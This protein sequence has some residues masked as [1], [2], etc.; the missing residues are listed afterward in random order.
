MRIVLRGGSVIAE[1]FAP[2]EQLAE[3]QAASLSEVKVMGCC[4]EVTKEASVRRTKMQAALMDKATEAD[5]P[6]EQA[7]ASDE[8]FALYDFD[9]SKIDWPFSDQQPLALTA[10]DKIRV[11]LDAAD[12]SGDWAFGQRIGEPAAE[13]Y[14]PRSYVGSKEDFLE[15]QAA[16]EAVVGATSRPSSAQSVLSVAVALYD[17]DPSTVDW[18]FEDDRPL[19]L[20]AGCEVQMLPLRQDIPSDWARG[21]LVG[22]PEVHGYF[23]KTYVGSKRHLFA[24]EQARDA[25]Q[26]VKKLQPV[27][28][29]VFALYNF[30]PTKMD[31]PFPDLSPLAF[32]AGDE[33]KLLPDEADAPS[34]WAFGQRA[35][36]PEATGYF[37]RSYVGS[38]EEMSEAQS[39][40]LSARSVSSVAVALYDFDP[41]GVDW[42]F[43]EDKPLILT[44]G[45][46]IQMLPVSADTPSD[47]AKGHV[48]GQPEIC[49]FFPRA[50]VGSKRHHDVV[51]QA[52]ES[53]SKVKGTSRPQSHSEVADSQRI[54]VF[55]LYEFDPTKIEWPF[56]DQPPLALSEGEAIRMWLDAS[57]EA[58]DWAFGQQVAEPHA[59]GYFPKAY[60]GSKE[61]LLEAQSMEAAA[62]ESASRPSSAASSDSVMVALYDFDPAGLAWPFQDAGPLVLKAGD[63]I[64]LLPADRE[65]PSDWVF[66]HHLAVPGSPGYLPKAYIGSRKH[67][68]VVAQ[69]QEAARQ[70]KPTIGPLPIE[71]ES[72]PEGEYE[73][74]VDNKFLRSPCKG[75]LHR[76]SKN[77]D[78][79]STECST[80]WGSTVRGTATGDGWLHLNNGLFL[81]LRIA[82]V[83]I[84]KAV[85]PVDAQG[86]AILEE[87]SENDWASVASEV[88]AL[89]DFDPARMDWPFPDHPPLALFAGEKV[90]LQPGGREALGD[91]GFGYRVADPQTK[92]L[93][94]R[95]YVGNREALLEAQSE[96]DTV[97][98][99][100]TPASLDSRTSVVIALYDFDP[101]SIEW[102][103][104]NLHSL[105]LVSGDEIQLLP[106][107]DNAPS[108]WALGHHVG[109]P[110][111]RGCFP[112]AYVGSRRHHKVITKAQ[113]AAEIARKARQQWKDQ[114]LKADD[115]EGAG[116]AHGDSE[117][118]ALYDFDPS[119][120]DW[121]FPDQKPLALSVG[122]KIVLLPLGVG[123]P[124]DWAFGHRAADLDSQ[125]YF[126]RAYIG[127]AFELSEALAAEEAL[128]QSSTPSSDGSAHS[129]A[130]ALYDFDASG[131]EW[132]FENLRP[133][134]LKAGDEVQLLPMGDG[135][136]NDWA[137]GH[138][139]GQPDSRGCFP[140]AYVGSRH[141]HRIVARAQAAA[142]RATQAAKFFEHGSSSPF[143]VF[144]L[145]DFDASKIDW[146]FEEHP[147]LTLTAGEKIVLLPGFEDAPGDWSLGHRAADR[148]QQGL[149]P[150]SYVG[151]RSEL[152]AAQGEEGSLEASLTPS[153][154]SSGVSVVVALHDFDPSTIEWPF[155]NLPSL[156]LTAGDEIQLLPMADDAPSD[157]A[158]GHHVGR[159]ESRGCF[160]KAYIGSKHH[161]K[162][163]EKVER[164]A[165]SAS[166]AQKDA[167][168]QGSIVAK[169]GEQQLLLEVFALYDFDPSK[170][171]WPFPNHHPLGLSAGEKI[172]LLPGTESVPGEWAFGHRV[173]DPSSQGFFPKAYVGSRDELW[174]AKA[175]EATLEKVSTP[176]SAVSA[177]SAVAVALFD[178]DPAAMEWPFPNLQP[179]AL[180]AGD[181]IQLLPM[182]DDA[183]TDWVLGHLVGEPEVRGCFPKDYIGSRH[184][185]QVVVQGQEAA[186]K[187]RSSSKKEAEE[188][189]HV[190]SS[191]SPSEL[192]A[193]Y[194]FDP[195]T[196]DWPFPENPPLGLI[197]GEKIVL[198]P[199]SDQA[200]GDWVVGQRAGD[201][202]AKGVLP[203]T[204][205]GTKEEL[206]D[207][208]ASSV[209]DG[210]ESA[211]S[212]VSLESSEITKQAKQQ[213]LV[214]Q[215]KRKHDTV[216]AT[217]EA[218]DYV[219]DNSQLQSPCKGILHRL[220]MHMDNVAW[221]EAT[222]WGSVV[223]GADMGNGWL[224]LTSGLY[225]PL[226]ISGIP[227][228]I[229]RS[230]INDFVTPASTPRTLAVAL[231]EFSPEKMDWPFKNRAPLPLAPGEEIELVPM[232]DDA[233]VEW[234]V[235]HPV[236]KPHLKGWFPRNYVGYAIKRPREGDSIEAS[237]AVALYPFSP[238]EIEWPFKTRSP[239]ALSPG[240][241]IQLI[242][243]KGDAEDE[244]W[245]LGHPV[246][247]PDQQGFFPK[248]YVSPPVKF[249]DA[250]GPVVAPVP[251]GSAVSVA[252]YT[253]DPAG[254]ERAF[255]HRSPLALTPG[256][257]I[258]LL[259]TKFDQPV[260]WAFGH[261]VGSPEATGYFPSKYV[262]VGEDEA[263][264]EDG[265]AGPLGIAL[266]SFDCSGTWPFPHR[267]PLSFSEGDAIKILPLQ[268]DPGMEWAFGHRVGAPYEKG[269]FP[270]SYISTPISF[271]DDTVL[272]SPAQATVVALYDFD[273]IEVEW[274]FHDR[275]P[276]AISAGDRIK[277]LP[278]QDD[279]TEEDGTTRWAFGESLDGSGS[280]GYFPKDFIGL[281]LDDE[282]LADKAPIAVALYDFDASQA[283]FVFPD[284]A[285]SL[286]MSA[287]DEIQLLHMHR[288]GGD[289]DDWALGHIVGKP[290]TKGYFPKSFVALKDASEV[291]AKVIASVR[292]QSLAVAEDED[293]F[294]DEKAQYF[295]VD[296]SL[297]H[298]PSNGILHRYSRHAEDIC[299]S[300][301]TAWGDT[302]SGIDCGDG[303]IKMAS[304]LFLPKTLNGIP[305]V[306]AKE[307]WD[308]E[309][310]ELEEEEAEESVET[311]AELTFKDL[312]FETLDHEAFK[313]E[314][315]D[316]M[317]KA[318]V[319]RPV[320][321]KMRIVLRG[322]S[323]IAEIFTPAEQLAE[324][325]AAPL[326]EVKVMGCCA[327]VTKEA[328]VRPTK[329]QAALVDKAPEVEQSDAGAVEQQVEAAAR[330]KSRKNTRVERNRVAR[331]R[332][333]KEEQERLQA[334]AA[335]AA[336]RAEEE[337]LAQE[338]A[339]LREEE[340]LA[341]EEEA[342][343]LAREAEQKADE[344]RLAREAEELRRKAEE[345]RLA[346]EAALRAEEERL[347]AEARAIAEKERAERE[348]ARKKEEMEREA[349]ERAI[350]EDEDATSH[351][352]TLAWQR[353][354]EEAAVEDAARRVHDARL[355]R[356]AQ[357][358][359]AAS[360][361]RPVQADQV[362]ALK[363]T[364]IGASGLRVGD[365]VS[366]SGPYCI[367]RIPSRPSTEVKTQVH[368]DKLNPVWG[369]TY[370]IS[371]YAV[372]DPLELLIR[373]S[374]DELILGRVLLQGHRFYPNGLEADLDLAGSARA[375][376][377]TLK[378]QV[379]VPSQA[380]VEQPCRGPAGG[381][382]GAGRKLEMPS[383]PKRMEHETPEEF[384]KRRMAEM[385]EA[386]KRKA[387]EK[388]KALK[389]QM[390]RE[391]AKRKAEQVLTLHVRVPN[392]SG[393]VYKIRCKAG[394]LLNEAAGAV[395]RKAALAVRP[396]LFLD[397]KEL[398]PARTLLD[399]GIQSGAEIL[400]KSFS[401]VLTS[402]RD[403]TAK[404]WNAQTG[405]CELSLTGH[406]DAVNTASYSP[407][408]KLIITASDDKTA[409][410]WSVDKG[411]C[412]AT[413]AGHRGS[414]LSAVFSDDCHR[415]LTMSDDGTTKIWGI[416]HG[417]CE[418]TLRHG[419][420]VLSASF[421]DNGK[422]IK[423]VGQDGTVK[424]W[425]AKSGVCER[426]L[427]GQTQVNYLAGA[428]F[429]VDGKSFVSPGGE[430]CAKIFNME[431]GRCE[432]EL[433]GHE[434]IVLAASFA[435]KA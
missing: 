170:M 345:E 186:E 142:A 208:Q 231:Y 218:V 105:T 391:E 109:R 16:D 414:V 271:S 46:E 383:S 180:V 53:A 136:P 154:T 273:P 155:E 433:L 304:G 161:R 194:D 290:D 360:Q 95:A 77:E 84:V 102:P 418:R 330:S 36:E 280:K 298:A 253:F 242:P 320:L 331:E 221:K 203:R 9:P 173:G 146:P 308:D 346:R 125:G 168:K 431:S 265:G 359:F 176:S 239:L 206:D 336:K 111:S 301:G 143:E 295:V 404:V 398:D 353:E 328:S 156:A 141:R 187:A 96:A 322:G 390:D 323:V 177:N 277:L 268:E 131:V 210:S 20:V 190:K 91:W 314:L 411:E 227:I 37:P 82:G 429:A 347:E 287:G 67:H 356:E 421:T 316:G 212:R 224:A 296:N 45:S 204:Y 126:P 267:T 144:A 48:I 376:I 413:F 270:K 291:V 201:P 58:G 189:A 100:N 326:S 117:V 392:A 89:Y 318:G 223:S 38:R 407:D 230:E 245:L 132:P 368:K 248:A 160:P 97:E 358:K 139:V 205:L 397:G 289:V 341:R 157:W 344:E 363:I 202:D 197:A 80:T 182:G 357:K 39:G 41:S 234:A 250:R 246:G 419:C 220:S 400:A 259:H 319:S 351:E 71:T 64:R 15:A 285:P 49:G 365:S 106:M 258:M 338:A 159:P 342:Q 140:R 78:D 260:Q 373:D 69:A 366:E 371:D 425:N 90:V 5:Q 367:C 7:S 364:I 215:E 119:K 4:A 370:D 43:E 22:Q 355:A 108:D 19:T 423:T 86:D 63:E 262:D 28:D 153:S 217:Q 73:Y 18:P 120:I 152:A 23:P 269:Y 61:E 113:E 114:E 193:L 286:S 266:C 118:F 254:L 310:E 92:G 8:V 332:A 56:A 361:G 50:Y 17:F 99:L 81:P 66:G 388:A 87:S 430:H 340:R 116:E 88:F 238:S 408:C 374:S 163:I 229:P 299:D 29:D 235:G 55:A 375:A 195:G 200:P 21:H 283:E 222:A 428:S 241:E 303:W 409:K 362:A 54:E 335:E 68:K 403:R 321:D 393:I 297:L 276:L 213:S 384:E 171:H 369:H 207:I 348:A 135:A 74:L 329:V 122:E 379:E 244:E 72:L 62:V 237:V 191:S 11:R 339:R 399:L 184:H 382:M 183:P 263:K 40:E 2:A 35:S 305:V 427:L 211:R 232:E 167:V 94:P 1:I 59:E 3:F 385:V 284:A 307:S 333:E 306:I 389:E 57:D 252:L 13:G 294:D 415:V 179:L 292:G 434:D 288:P 70:V 394:A 98:R 104:Q 236:G 107:G 416:K 93:F 293:D 112:K 410:L 85:G 380:A 396:E 282:Q 79:V 124:Q 178:F 401:A 216:W 257:E 402:S 350:M 31:W 249:S 279:V 115:K 334:E 274:T 188:K 243:S 412:L 377:G 185:H 324:V 34:D 175:E 76:K 27:S 214:Q 386:A 435:P 225:L 406:T 51:V 133:L 240:D 378:I 166:S 233:H 313:A 251:P 181:E 432:K 372:G 417:C 165:E 138:L 129:V 226:R 158:L 352:A 26:K 103:F 275:S 300:M 145:Y 130:V 110:E 123:T 6:D 14:F 75:I 150:K 281:P 311:H 327:Q 219:V 426:T 128:E 44:A 315:K 422:G 343:R 10:G 147:P 349:E 278:P 228:L 25:V 247:H 162:S 60:V 395:I 127:S 52:R 151:S 33:L 209:G 149:F 192:Y 420:P 198:L 174:E 24:A 101:S 302:I 312:C 83:T 148:H 405:V 387:E 121:P 32:S 256:E 137:L 172:I 42:P 199:E 47:W 261:R 30:D 164:A 169:E 264:R 12:D 134:S 337:R 255:G 381:R 317:E 325:K 424:L 354:E 272:P 196:L 309:E 65:A